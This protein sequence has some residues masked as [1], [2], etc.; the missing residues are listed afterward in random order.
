MPNPV[1][2]WSSIPVYGKWLNIDGTAKTGSI[3]VTLPVRV[4]N[5]P[6]DA[7]FP[8][9][10]VL[11]AVPLNTSGYA[12]I[13]VPSNNDPDNSPNGWQA[14]VTVT[15]SNGKSPS[16]VYVI[17]T[18][19]SALDN[20]PPGIDLAQVLVPALIPVPQQPLYIGVAGGV[21]K[22]DA[23]GN[24]IDASGAV[25]GTGSGGGGTTT[26]AS[27]L[28]SGFL[29]IARIPDGA[30]GSAKVDGSIA[31]TADI[32]VAVNDAENRA[33]H[34]GIQAQSTITG[35]TSALLA[36]ADATA[37]TAAL[38]AKADATA[39]T[40]AL[41][42]KLAKPTS[43]P[44]GGGAVLIAT[45]GTTSVGTS[46]GTYYATLSAATTAAAAGQIAVGQII[47]VGT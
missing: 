34:Y 11:A 39:T 46:S 2:S 7:I 26:N 20:T 12:S 36:K 1:A 41:G 47:T 42:N 19:L 31:R 35:L 45:D 40:T 44:T 3:S 22:L 5:T 6:S 29:P 43:I 23:D 8:Q 38:G 25:V 18:P 30:I 16:E 14:T 24:V 9:G 21:A 32:S 17:D 27:A 33:N 10:Q 15:F 28:T 13:D 4:V 37:T